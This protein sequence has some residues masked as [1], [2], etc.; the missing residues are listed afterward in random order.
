MYFFQSYLERVYVNE[1]DLEKYEVEICLNSHQTFY[2]NVDPL[3]GDLESRDKKGVFFD[4]AST[5]IKILH[6]CTI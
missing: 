6:R 5:I 3:C 2:I 1:K 4:N